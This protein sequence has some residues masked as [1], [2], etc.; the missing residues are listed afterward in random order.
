MNT[1]ITTALT[2]YVTNTALTNSLSAYT[3]TSNLTTL[4]ANKISTSHEANNIGASNVSYG[5]HERHVLDFYK[6]ES[7]SPTPLVLYIHGGGFVRG[8]KDTVNQETLK[9]LLDAGIS[10]AAIHYR[11]AGEV[12]LPAAHED[13]QRAIQTLRSKADKWNVDKTQVGAFGRSSGAQL[14]MWLD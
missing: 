9:Q 3:D 8:S 4:L 2:S 11:L 13:A 5:E 10:V 6:A 14:C 1:A 12:P 7:S